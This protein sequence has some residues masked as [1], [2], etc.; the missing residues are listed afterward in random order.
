MKAKGFLLIVAAFLA[1][2]CAKS[3]YRFD[4]YDRRLESY[5]ASPEKVD[6]YQKALG[7]IIEK[8][9]SEGRRVPPGIYAEY[10]RVLYDRQQYAQSIEYF[11]LEKNTY[12]E[13]AV[14]MDRMIANAARLSG[15]GR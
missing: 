8:S 13:S 3:I 10:G 7:R 9:K 6:T 14:L 12:I 4:A 5:L 11:E 2:G 1:L 15:G